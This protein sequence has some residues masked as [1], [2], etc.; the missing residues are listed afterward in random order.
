MP[1]SVASIDVTT[2]DLMFLTKCLMSDV[3]AHK[4]DVS[5]FGCNNIHQSIKYYVLFRNCKSFIQ[6]TVALHSDV[7]KLFFFF[8][9]FVPS[10]Q[11][12]TICF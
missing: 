11:T 1:S 6:L 5:Y 4:F 8:F 10:Y 7:K 2:S 3:F 9:L 12:Q